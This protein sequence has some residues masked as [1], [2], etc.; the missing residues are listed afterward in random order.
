MEQERVT[1]YRPN[2]SWSWTYRL[3]GM[4]LS[5]TP[6]FPTAK[7]AMKAGQRE[8]KKIRGDER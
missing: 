6:T 1:V 2:S 3:R 5:L 8:W 4:P 7:Q